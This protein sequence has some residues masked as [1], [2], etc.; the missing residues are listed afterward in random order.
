M[1]VY[2]YPLVH[3]SVHGCASACMQAFGSTFLFVSVSALNLNA[4]V[5]PFIRV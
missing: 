4:L 2:L 1:W 3:V 5:S